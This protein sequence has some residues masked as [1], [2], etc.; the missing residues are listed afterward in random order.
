MGGFYKTAQYLCDLDEQASHK[1][2]SESTFEKTYK[3]Y[4]TCNFNVKYLWKYIEP[5]FYAALTSLKPSRASVC[6][7]NDS[8]SCL[9][10]ASPWCNFDCRLIIESFR[11]EK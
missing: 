1:N 3:K 11:S 5:C 10:Q 4:T 7:S 6:E 2:R 8:V 9:L